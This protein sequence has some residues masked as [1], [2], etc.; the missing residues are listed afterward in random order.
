MVLH[1]ATDDILTVHNIVLAPYQKQTSV[2]HK[3]SRASLSTCRQLSMHRSHNLISYIKLHIK[4]NK[5]DY[6]IV[7]LK[8][9]GTDDKTVRDL[10]DISQKLTG[11]DYKRLIGKVNRRQKIQKN[12][13]YMYYFLFSLTCDDT[14]SDVQNIKM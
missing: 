7:D 12:Q 2:C 3:Q 6:N 10:F 9:A 14:V 4:N 5:K 8:K 11:Y 13:K 1:A